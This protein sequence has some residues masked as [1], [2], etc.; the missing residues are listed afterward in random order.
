MRMSLALGS[1]NFGL[2]GRGRCKMVL[3][4]LCGAR[5]GHDRKELRFWSSE[6][7]GVRAY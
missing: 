3:A 7:H 6:V 4:R 5:C 2:A 1:V